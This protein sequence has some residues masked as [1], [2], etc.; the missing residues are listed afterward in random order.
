MKEKTILLSNRNQIKDDNRNINQNIFKDNYNL[1]F[2]N[3]QKIFS[4]SFFHSTFL[5]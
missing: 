2:R 3:T 1:K 5:L 4:T